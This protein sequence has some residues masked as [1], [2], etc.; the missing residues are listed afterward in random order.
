MRAAPGLGLLSD[1]FGRRP[2]LL[3]C[4]LGSALGY[5]M[6]GLGGALWVLFLS[7]IIDA[8]EIRRILGIENSRNQNTED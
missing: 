3:I 7:R 5:I 4:M 1:H 6:F 2:L 8:G